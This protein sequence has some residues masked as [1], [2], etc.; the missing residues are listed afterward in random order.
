MFSPFPT[1]EPT[2]DLTD[3]TKTDYQW[4]GDMD[5]YV[6]YEEL[7]RESL[8]ADNPYDTFLFDIN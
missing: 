4:Q 5:G 3:E 1:E 6:S 2:V 7:L 8:T